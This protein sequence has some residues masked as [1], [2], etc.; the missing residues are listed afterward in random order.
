MVRVAKIMLSFAAVVVLL[1]LTK[2]L[3][4][5]KYFD[6][7][8]PNFPFHVRDVATVV[9]DDELETFGIL[10]P[11]R[12]EKE[13]FT[14]DARPNEAMPAVL[15]LP[16]DRTGAV[17]LVIFIHGGGQDKHF[18]EE[19]A[20]PFNEAGFAMAS[21]DQSTVGERKVDGGVLRRALAFRRS[22][23]KNVSDTRRLIDYLQ[24]HP[25]IDPGRIYL[26]GASFGAITGSTVTA[27]D[28]RIRAACLVVGGADNRLLLGAPA[29]RDRV[30]NRWLHWLAKN[31]VA[32]IMSPADPKHYAAHTEGTPV[33][34]QNGLWDTIVTPEAG[35]ALYNALGEPK[36]L[37]WYPCDHPGASEEEIPV[38]L[39]LLD[40]ALAWLLEH[41]R[42]FRDDA[43]PES[44]VRGLE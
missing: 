25:E 11:R 34:M 6:T 13:T 33:L 16:M 28:K 3:A 20:T 24:T 2:V 9:V 14:I 37:R 38:V 41:D 35:K 5:T 21:F 22:I 23:S 36:E 32:F 29:F 1:L 12:F 30:G 43:T 44:P 40:E 15:T 39:E 10:R 7:Y 18:V 4:D 19:I 31:I 42:P 8:D 27:F 17:P 26:T